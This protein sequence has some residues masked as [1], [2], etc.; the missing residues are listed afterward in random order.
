[1]NE[2]QPPGLGKGP[3]ARLW[4]SVT[5]VYTLRPD[6]LQVLEEA[7]RETNLVSEMRLELQKA[8]LLVKGSMGQ[9]VVH[10]LVAELGKHRAT[11]AALLRQLKLPDD[12]PGVAAAPTAVAGGATKNSDKGRAV[13]AGRWQRSG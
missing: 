4:K 1:M 12:P 3:G 7:C 10:P 8:D 2:R 9:T 6:E 13:A 5:T 11:V